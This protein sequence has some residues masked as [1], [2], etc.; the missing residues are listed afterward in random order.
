M[1]TECQVFFEPT[2]KPFA[3]SGIM[4][5]F[6][7]N[8]KD[9]FLILKDQL[10]YGSLCSLDRYKDLDEKT[11]DML[12]SEAI[13]FA[14]GVVDPLNEIGE[15]EG[16][17]FENG[18]VT[19]PQEFKKAFRQYGEDGW[20]AA[21]RSPKYGG[22]GFPNMMRI[23]INDMMYGA[24]QSFN[25]APSLTHGAAHLI[26]SFAAEELKGRFV[27]KMYNG[28][29]AGTMALTEPDAGSFLAN[30]ET[31]AYRD[32][33]RFKIKGTKMF[34]SWGE[35]DL[36]D[37]IIHLVLAR[38]EGAPEGVRGISLFVVPKMK[39]NEDGSVGGSND[40]IC[41]SI[42]E[43]MGLHAS[44]TAVLNLGG[45]DDCT[46]YLCGEENMGL[47][48][49]FQMMNQARINT[50][51]SGMSLASTAYLNALAYTRDRLQ[52][53][54]LAKRKK[55]NIPIIDHPDVRRMLLWMKANVDGMRSMI[56]TAAYW[57]DLALELPDGEEKDRYD[58]MVEF[59]TPIIKAFCSDMGF[60]VCETAMQCLGGYGFC[61]DYPI[62]QYLRDVKILSLYEGT[63]GIQSIDLLGRKLSMND[64]KPY[65]FIKEEIDKFCQQYKEHSRLGDK[66]R[67]LSGVMDRVGE[68][69]Q[70]LKERREKDV[71]QWASYTYPALMSIGEVIVAWRLLDL[72]MISEKLQEKAKGSKKEYYEGKILQASYYIDTVLPQ[73]LV[74]METC[75]RHGREIL[76]ITDNAF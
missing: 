48:H 25:M 16:V 54:D 12:V 11:L 21:A 10:N 19:C 36:T 13:T 58:N 31:T 49:M 4:G 50:G 14:K 72:A 45:R 43:K 37:N 73:T 29:W 44:P 60:R 26:E 46:G 66:V 33:D 18:K 5:D 69:T 59:L 57:S 55:G 8:Q 40:V 68:I 51:V 67:A 2:L 63:N 62:E 9:I 35:H 30:V 34:I 61:S 65:R 22:Q 70:E 47:A 23:I 3:V 71:L 64:G 39:V 74:N 53:R 7:V 27:E 32:G 1:L 75:L 28:A 56:Y 17:K 42:E 38:I 41:G 24:C 15:R 52:G 6:K 76:D 20:T